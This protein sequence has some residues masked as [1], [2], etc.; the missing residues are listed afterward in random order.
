MSARLTLMTVHAHPDDETISTGGVMARY[1]AE[2]ARVVCVTCTGGEHGE[3]VVP[4]LDTPE[5]HAKLGEIRAEELRKALAALGNVESRKLGYVDSGMMGTPENDAPASFWQADF[6]AA[7]ER[8]LA[9][10]RVVRPQVI[11]GYND[12]GGYGHPDHIRAA[13]TAKA[14]FERSVA[15]DG[16]S[17]PIK[18]Y[19]TAFNFRRNEAVMERAKER[20]VKTWWEQSETETDEQ[21]TQREE[22]MRKMAEATGPVT[23]T[24]EVGDYVG[25]KLAAL[26]EHV[27]QLQQDGFFLAF[28]VDDW[29]EL[30]HTE[31][32]TLRVSRS[33]VRIPE[34]DLFGGLR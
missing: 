34:D 27:T 31:E 4:E 10:V 17:A 33:G 11:V 28:T 23:T 21:R 5:N 14:A 26:K 19:E 3:I 22:Q 15:E 20:G 13:L 8:L 18:L 32:F 12:F 16:D 6:D 7:V 30:M 9:I 24:V 29:R 1:A 2:G 25:N